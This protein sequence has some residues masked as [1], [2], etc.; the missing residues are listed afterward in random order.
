[1]RNRQL[2]MREYNKLHPEKHRAANLKYER[3][4]KDRVVNR[5]LLQKYGISL[6][7]KIQLFE[8]QLGLCAICEFK[9]ETVYSAHVDHDHKTGKVRGLLCLTCNHLIG[10]AKDSVSILQK[11]ATYLTSLDS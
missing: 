6:Q 5:K 9:F 10:K 11:A 2:Y 3:V 1:M 4:H 8:K 7:E